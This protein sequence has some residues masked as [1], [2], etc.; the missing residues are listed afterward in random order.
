MQWLKRLWLD[1]VRLVYPAHCPGCGTD[2][3]EGESGV[4]NACLGLMERTGFEAYPDNNEMYLRLASS[5]PVAG[6]VAC[7]WFEKG[8]RIQEIL[9]TLKY[10]H[11]PQAGVTLGRTFGRLLADT[12]NF[13]SDLTLVPLPL[14]RR[15]E[16]ERGY[17]QSE[18][19]AAG[20]AE[21]TGWTVDAGLLERIRYTHT[22]TAKSRE[23]RAENIRGAFRATAGKPV[24][25]IGLVDDVCTTGATLA[26]AVGALSEAYPG[27]PVYVFTAA[28][29]RH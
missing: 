2:L 5:L 26:A 11:Q 3:L 15:R 13:P 19:I 25:A 14:H 10:H 29:A 16:E 8:S 23:E 20:M 6:M 9:H 17:N 22:Q 1:L 24:H 18:R 12:G 28:L 4:C 7:W 21:A 27:I